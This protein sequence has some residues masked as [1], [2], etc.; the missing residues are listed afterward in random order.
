M[1]QIYKCYKTGDIIFTY[2]IGDSI[3]P[4]F[5]NCQYLQV[6][7]KTTTIRVKISE[8]PKEK[9]KGNTILLIFPKISEV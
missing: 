5:T 9:K 6:P 4:D 3:F 7:K 2:Q 8:S 1:L